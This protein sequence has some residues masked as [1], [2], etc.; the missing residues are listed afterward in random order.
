MVYRLYAYMIRTITLNE[1]DL[2]QE[3]QG[4]FALFY[5]WFENGKADNKPMV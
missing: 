2:D 3:I 1:I 4:V 5:T